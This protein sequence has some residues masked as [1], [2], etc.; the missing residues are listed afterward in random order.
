MD[1][2]DE[3]I[4]IKRVKEGDLSAF[5]KLVDKY[6]E[7][8][9]TLAYNVLLHK[10]DAE[11]VAQD[12]FIKAFTSLKSFKGTSRFSTWFYRI[13]LNTALNRLKRRK[14]EIPPEKEVYENDA[15]DLSSIRNFSGADQKRF[16]QQAISFLSE[17]ERVCI[18][19]YYLHELSVDEI[20]DT[21]GF[22]AANIKVLLY[23]GRKH[24]YE[25]LHRILKHELNDLI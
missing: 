4:I 13:V 14:L 24:L 16:I 15:H 25:E 11:D 9:V 8:A 2:Q 20:N 10:E 19:L 18:I 6:K 7:L 12:S 5:A 1:V 21:I 22:S 3:L 17:G 23:R